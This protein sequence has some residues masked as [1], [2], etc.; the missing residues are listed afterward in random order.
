M[1]TVDLKVAMAQFAGLGRWTCI[2]GACSSGA[3]VKY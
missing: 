3:E 2:E 1:T